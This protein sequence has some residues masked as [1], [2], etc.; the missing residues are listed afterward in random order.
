MTISDYDGA[1][2]ALQNQ[3]YKAAANQ[4]NSDEDMKLKAE[5]ER[6]GELMGNHSQMVGGKLGEVLSNYEDR[7]LDELAQKASEEGDSDREN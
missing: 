1:L 2:Q 4:L 6:L 3:K 7:L 5:L